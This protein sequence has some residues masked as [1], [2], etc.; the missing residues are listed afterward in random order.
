MLAERRK[1]KPTPSLRGKNG[2]LRW[3]RRQRRSLRRTRTTTP[4]APGTSNTPRGDDRPGADAAGIGTH[5]IVGGAGTAASCSPR[6]PVTKLPK[7]KRGKAGTSKVAAEQRRLPFVRAYINNG[8][9]ITQAAITIGCSPRSAGTLGYRLF[10]DVQT[11]ALLKQEIDRLNAAT[12]LSVE[13][14]L[15]ELAR[16]A[17]S[18]PRRLF[19]DGKPIPIHEL[20]DDAAATIASIEIEEQYTGKGKKR[21]VASFTRKVRQWDKNSAI[22]KAMKYHRLYEVDAPPPPTG[23]TIIIQ[24]ARYDEDI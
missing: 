22:E 13:R 14:T 18:D 1:Q 4:A 7:K 9:N 24:A 23:T 5:F 6:Q 21:T 3:Y 15:R 8:N 10:K 19:K 12:G 2:L 16:L 11:Q 17:Y 20:D